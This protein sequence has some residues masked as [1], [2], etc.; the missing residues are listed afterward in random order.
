MEQKQKKSHWNQVLVEID[1]ET[2]QIRNHWNLIPIM[3]TFFFYFIKVIVFTIL[4]AKRAG[5]PAA[6]KLAGS[7]PTKSPKIE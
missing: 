6:T 5:T 4:L 7:V 1:V 3:M 2:I